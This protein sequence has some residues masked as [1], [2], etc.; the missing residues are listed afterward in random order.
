[1]H[2]VELLRLFMGEKWS[3]ANS[4]REEHHIVRDF[5]NL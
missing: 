1:M 2:H 3:A 5:Y 4:A